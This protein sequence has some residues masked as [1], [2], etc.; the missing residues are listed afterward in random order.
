MG[1]NKRLC[2][3]L[4]RYAGVLK[5]CKDDSQE[6]KQPNSLPHPVRESA[7]LSAGSQVRGSFQL[8]HSMAHTHS[9]N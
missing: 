3:G 7:A 2:E 4:S 8:E 6:S 9:I 1:K 5:G